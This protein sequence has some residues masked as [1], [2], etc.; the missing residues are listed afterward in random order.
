M[1]KKRALICPMDWGLGHAT[2][3]V[4]II[5]HLIELGYEVII[6]AD[7]APLFFLRQYFPALSFIVIPSITIRYPIKDSLMP[8]K[9][10]VSLPLILH[11]IIME[12]RQMKQIIRINHFDLVISDNRYGLWNKT[13]YSIFIT[14]QLQIFMPRWMKFMESSI[15]LINYW[16]INKYNECWVPDLDGEINF[17][18]KLSHPLKLPDNLHYIGILSRFS[19]GFKALQHPEIGNGFD[20]LILL[21][22]PEPQR[23]IL[24]NLIIRQLADLP[25]KCL[26]VQGK[27]LE[28][29]YTQSPKLKIVNHLKSEHLGYL[30]LNTPI[31]IARSG[32]STIMDFIALKKHAILVP[33]P[34]QTEQ[35]YLANY[36]MKKMW[37]CT[38]KQDE[39]NLNQAIETFNIFD[40]ESFPEYDNL[41]NEKLAKLN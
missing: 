13:V 38:V 6:G 18:G 17:A 1:T 9:M 11:G 21:S 27:P 19:N 5:K 8:W 14:H 41:I 20:I 4:H 10:L 28:N 33:T 3:D 15:R 32:Y 7:K 36:M 40:F 23:G 24:E 31:V 30:I 26:I 39:F 22:G 12:H 34:G 29:S 2:R 16:F 37:F 35:E 25:F